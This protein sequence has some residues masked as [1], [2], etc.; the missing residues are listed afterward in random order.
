MSYDIWLEIDVG[1]DAPHELTNTHSPTYN[2]HDMFELALGGPMRE[3]DGKT[4]AECAPVLRAAVAQMRRTP[5]RFKKLNPPNGWGSYEGAVA[6]L[7]WLLSKCLA[8]PKATVR[9]R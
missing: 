1:A 7:G 3:L 9:V 2:L 8:F 5:A 4:G 6:T